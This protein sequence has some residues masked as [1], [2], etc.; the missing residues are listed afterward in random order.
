SG[1]ASNR[2][3]FGVGL[4]FEKK[5]FERSGR[6]IW[7]QL[8]I[9]FLILQ[10]ASIHL[11]VTRDMLHLLLGLESKGDNLSTDVFIRLVGGKLEA[12]SIAA[13]ACSIRFDLVRKQRP[14]QL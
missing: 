7:L 12:Q 5:G 8:L 9:V 6:E 1:I 13:E 3:I 14:Q 4:L 11:S 10:S 2:N